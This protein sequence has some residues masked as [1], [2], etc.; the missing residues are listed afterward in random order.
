MRGCYDDH[1]KEIQ[2]QS[3]NYLFTFENMI[4]IFTKINIYYPENGNFKMLPLHHYIPW[5]SSTHISIRLGVL[6]WLT[7]A[8]LHRLT[9][10]S[11]AYGIKGLDLQL[12]FGPLLQTLQSD[13]PLQPVIHQSCAGLTQQV[14]SQHSDPVAHALRVSIVLC[15]WQW[16]RG[17][18]T[19]VI[20]QQNYR[21]RCS[22]T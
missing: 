12:V 14:C 6:T 11:E 20:S 18:I 17:N 13:L 21:Q 9:P 2:F 15:L 19:L 16:L 4:I 22:S 5:G 8:S 7:R 3:V 10:G 1:I